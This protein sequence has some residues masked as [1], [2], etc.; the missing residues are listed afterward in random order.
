MVG[1]VEGV[2]S[3][4]NVSMGDPS[5]PNGMLTEVEVQK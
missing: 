2:T 4:A 5:D 3:L 1:H